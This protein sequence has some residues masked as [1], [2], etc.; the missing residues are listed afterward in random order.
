MTS[1]VV[2]KVL[3]P[4]GV[5]PLSEVRVHKMP[6]PKPPGCLKVQC[7][8]SIVNNMDKYWCQD[9]MQN[10][11][12]QSKSY[13]FVLGPFEDLPSP[14]IELIIEELN[15]SGK[16]RKHHLHLLLLY[17]LERLVLTRCTSEF[18][19]IIS[20]CA[21]RCKKLRHIGLKGRT[22]PRKILNEMFKSLSLLQTVDL[23]QTNV[24]DQT[25]SVISAYCKHVRVLNLSDTD[26]TD[27]GV[28]SLCHGIMSS[29]ILPT[30]KP[31]IS[32]SII[33]LDL[34]G[35]AV[36]DKGIQCALVNLPNLQEITH[37][38]LLYALANLKKS[39]EKMAEVSV[40]IGS[41]VPEFGPLKLR[42]LQCDEF[43]SGNLGHFANAQFI[44]PAINLCPNIQYVH[45]RDLGNIKTDSLLPLLTLNNVIDLVLEFN[46]PNQVSF[47]TQIVPLL[48]KHGETLRNLQLRFVANINLI[49]IAYLCPELNTLSLDGLNTYSDYDPSKVHA[50]PRDVKPSFSHLKSIN[51]NC[52]PI[53]EVLALTFHVPTDGLRLIL[54]SPVLEKIIVIEQDN[55]N[56]E[57]L[58]NAVRTSKF[59]RLRLLSLTQCK[60]ITI[61]S[62]RYVIR[63]NNPLETLHI[64]YC[65]NITNVDYHKLEKYV[66]KQRLLVELAWF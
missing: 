10:W 28:S 36:T 26:V 18:G 44:N 27:M 60:N 20:L 40:D 46:G 34:Y 42:F 7:V 50:V 31:H 8:R 57:I 16:L 30:E 47:C 49:V 5:T 22:L 58:I 51:I 61:E 12:D 54:E 6:R 21:V 2:N 65:Q 19:Y 14:L 23:S 17:H 43:G 53:S 41:I 25:I 64:I 39:R 24:T 55:L 62:I 38:T 66:E 59:P 15:T 56:D 32:K 3:G 13:L 9:Y 4:G 63:L 37:S 45:L 11:L 35:T 29:D 48:H 52:A 33:K 1:Q